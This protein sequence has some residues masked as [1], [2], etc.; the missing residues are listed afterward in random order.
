M[1]TTLPED[2][3]IKCEQ[4]PDGRAT[5]NQEQ[6]LKE[7][8]QWCHSQ[9]VQGKIKLH[10][11]DEYDAETGQVPNTYIAQLAMKNRVLN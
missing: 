5:V 10:E 2:F 9:I 7:W 8:A 3:L 1:Q 6:W 4:L 11:V